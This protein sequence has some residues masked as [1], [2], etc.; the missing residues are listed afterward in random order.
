MTLRPPRSSRL[1][2]SLAMALLVAWAAARPAGAQTL[3]GVDPYRPYN[4]AYIPFSVPPAPTSNYN[5]LE[6]S[7][8]DGASRANQMGS[9]YEELYGTSDP[10]SS[11]RRSGP[12][13][14]YSAANRQYDNDFNRIYRPNNGDTQFY[15]EQKKRDEDYFRALQERDPRKRAELLRS[16]E[17]RTLESTRDLGPNARRPGNP[18][19][20]SPSS[21]PRTGPTD[22]RGPLDANPVRPSTPRATSSPAATR[23][24]RPPAS[25]SGSPPSG[26]GT[27]PRASRSP[28]DPL[29][30]TGLE[31]AADPNSAAEGSPRFP[32]YDPSRR[33]RSPYGDP[34]FRSTSPYATGSTGRSATRPSNSELAPAPR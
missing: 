27:S 6:G 21:N 34:A 22:D 24:V 9:F 29:A 33:L 31:P 26:L 2:P 20:A 8:F 13:V 16:I 32:Y 25:T 12:G 19:S 7:R 4:N 3:L 28:A 10:G 5:A 11:F 15:E 18:G 1:T 30:R 17:R 14:P 23:G